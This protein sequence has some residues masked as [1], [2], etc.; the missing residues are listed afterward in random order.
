MN[1]KV[2]T[3]FFKYFLI[4]FGLLLIIISI[5]FG[6]R[7]IPVSELKTKYAEPPSSFIELNGM[8]VHCRDEGNASDSIPIVL[9]HGT[10]SSLHTF[11]DW[12][13][14]LKN[15]RRVI[16]MDLPG[17]GLTGPFQDNNYAIENYV[18]FIHNFL[19]SKGVEKCI[20][21]GNSLGGEIAWRFTADNPQRVE[22]L[23]LINAAGYPL[24]S[25]SKPIAFRLARTPVLKNVLTFITPRS[26]VKSSVE[27]VYFDQSKVTDPLVDRYFDLTLRE[28]NR[29]ALIDRMAL[30]TESDKTGLIKQIK[31]PTL[32]LWGEHDLLIPTDYAHRF[33]K[34][35]PNS[36][37]VI[38]E[39]V[40]H[41]PME[42]SP[43]ESL[44]AVTNFL[45]D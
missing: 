27:N 31:T 28:G 38:I 45:N 22:K 7:D 11:N 33:H 40:G 30:A 37:L 32:V 23:I 34:D 42:E 2:L 4:A 39:K 29:N 8:E 44:S 5:L 35:L 26:L 12:A 9:I 18:G 19:V 43:K 13:N 21:G 6:H 10:S 41:V 20:L 17:F 25:K 1:M 14:V 24:E 36:S 16:R 15:G 3:A